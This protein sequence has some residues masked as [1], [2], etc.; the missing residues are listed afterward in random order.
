MKRTNN[1][2][3]YCMD[4]IRGELVCCPECKVTFPR[5]FTQFYYCPMCGERLR[6]DDELFEV[7]LYGLQV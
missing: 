2:W 5:Y 6:D 3:I 1:K 4:E 7:D